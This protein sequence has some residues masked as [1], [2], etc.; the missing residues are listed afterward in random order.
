MA[1][2]MVISLYRTVERA[3]SRFATFA[4]A[5]SSTKTTAPKIINRVGTNAA[6]D[7]VGDGNQIDAPALVCF[8]MFL[9]ESLGDDASSLCA[10]SIVA[11]GLSRAIARKCRRRVLYRHKLR[12]P[13]GKTVLP[14]QPRRRAAD[15]SLRPS[16]RRCC[17]AGR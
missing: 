5:T 16:R 8:R 2:R 11:P 13:G 10:C 3:S 17:M 15:G 14:A 9:L 6:N 7:I 4:Q 12:Q 1:A